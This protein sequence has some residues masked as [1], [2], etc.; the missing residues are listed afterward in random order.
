MSPQKDCDKTLRVKYHHNLMH[1]TNISEIEEQHNRNDDN[2]TDI[3]DDG[4][5]ASNDNN[6]HKP[7][8][9]NVDPTI[10]CPSTFRI[11]KV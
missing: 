2:D 6:N 4:G 1:E 9:Q 10:G 3:S 5:E 8:T 7:Q 11:T